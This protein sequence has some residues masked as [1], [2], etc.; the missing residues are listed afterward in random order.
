MRNAARKRVSR[1]GPAERMAL[2]HPPIACATRTFLLLAAMACAGGTVLA[3]EGQGAVGLDETPEELRARSEVKDLA[4]ALATAIPRAPASASDRE[5][6][7]HLAADP[8]TPAGRNVAGQGWAVTGEAPLPN[9]NQA[10]SFV[11]KFESGTSGSCLLSAGNVAIFHDENLLAIA[12]APR[13]SNQSIGRIVPLGD[14]QARIWSGDFLSQPVADLRVENEGYLL[15]LAPLA[16]EERLCG[17][18]AA[19][20]NIYGMNIDTARNVLESKGWTPVRGEIGN[21]RNQFGREIELVKRGIL[22]VESCSGTGFGYCSFLYRGSAGTLSVTT[23]GDD[24]LPGV[25][26]YS[27]ECR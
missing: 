20:P 2:R 3:R 18:R 27:V 23:V 15:A 22:E 16:A 25:S 1:A 7:A 6:C 9:G 24:D 19:V 4:I 17:G 12:Y 8:K 21:D 11:G 13:G 14:G 26:G 10:V 5:S